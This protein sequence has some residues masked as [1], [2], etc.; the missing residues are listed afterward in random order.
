MKISKELASE[1]LGKEVNWCRLEKEKPRNIGKSN[2][3]EIGYINGNTG[4]VN[5]YE[6]SNRCKKWARIRGYELWSAVLDVYSAN[7]SI[8]ST[9]MDVIDFDAE[10]EPEAIIK[11]TQWVIE[12]KDIAEG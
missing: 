6:F 5:I 3:L 2:F 10:T 11:A 1:V 4:L 12:N 7:C 9:R 8:Y